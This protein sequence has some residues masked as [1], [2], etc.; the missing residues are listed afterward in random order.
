M[1]SMRS[2]GKECGPASCTSVAFSACGTPNIIHQVSYRLIQ[3]NTH[4]AC[5]W[6]LAWRSAAAL[7]LCLLDLCD[8]SNTCRSHLSAFR[9]AMYDAMSS[10]LLMKGSSKP[11]VV[12]SGLQ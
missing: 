2:S 8:G 7:P 9:D 5:V 3:N 6:L 1:A 11:S 12:C 4:G 10:H